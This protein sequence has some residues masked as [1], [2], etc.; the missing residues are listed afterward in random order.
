MNQSKKGVLFLSYD[1]M[2]DPL[3]QSQVI[4]YLAGL[5]KAGYAIHLISFEKKERYPEGKAT[6]EALLNNANI[7]WHP[8]F[9]TKKPPVLSTIKDVRTMKKMAGKVIRDNNIGLVHCRSAIA[10]LVGLWAKENFACRMIYDM[11]GF[12]AD[13]RVDGKI[14]NL[15]NPVFLAVYKYFKRKELEFIREADYSVSLTENGKQEI[16][17]W[18]SFK[19]KSPLIKV[20]PCC[21]DLQHF[22][23][24]NYVEEDVLQ[25]R[26]KLGVRKEDFLLV[27]LGSLG[28]WYMVKEMLQYFSRLLLVK[29]EAKFL[30]ITTDDAGLV[31]QH[32]ASFSIPEKQVV[33]TAAKRKEIP[34]LLSM[35][36]FSLFFI[37]PVYSKKASSPTKLAELMA[38]SVPVVCNAGVGDVDRIVEQSQAGIVLH[39]FDNRS[40]DDAIQQMINYPTDAAKLRQAAIEYASLETGVKRYREIYQ[41]LLG[42]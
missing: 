24:D 38:L 29:P 21:A 30:L 15:N 2:T 33:I 8:A 28:T 23:K 41:L 17:S 3:G 14:W 7:V 37:L 13:E 27:Y 5:S 12:Y 9:Y 6:I 20:I 22:S 39:A 32:L 40:Y 18:E 1:G 4:P 42:Y 25:W 16:L 10:A 11:R 36:D 31:K 35:A 19:N 26:K 34:A